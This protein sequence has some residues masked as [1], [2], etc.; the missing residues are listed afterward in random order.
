M[1][2]SVGLETYTTSTNDVYDYELHEIIDELYHQLHVSKKFYINI[3]DNN[4][5]DKIFD[6]FSEQDNLIK[7]V[8]KNKY[9]QAN[10]N[11]T[12]QADLELQYPIQDMQYKLYVANSKE[13]L[14]QLLS[15]DFDILRKNE[16]SLLGIK[17]EL[18]FLDLYLFYEILPN[19][20]EA[21][22]VVEL[23]CDIAFYAT[24][25]F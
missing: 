16:T 7:K 8:L 10:I 23:N 15:V 20:E 2:L 9:P 19:D 21:I 4:S 25:L 22:E 3:Q 14:K 18:F 13:E 11:I 6:S 5:I 1:I 12:Y 17:Q 24:E